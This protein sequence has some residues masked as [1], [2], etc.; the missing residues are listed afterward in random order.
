MPLTRMS[1]KMCTLT[2]D[3]SQNIYEASKTD[4]VANIYT[5]QL[6]A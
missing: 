2:I 1:L 5:V 3:S 4:F 6:V